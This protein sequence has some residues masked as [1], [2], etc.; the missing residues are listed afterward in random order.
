MRSVRGD[1][2]ELRS[3]LA[4]SP[5]AAR[6]SRSD[7]GEH[8]GELDRIVSRIPHLLCARSRGH[9]MTSARPL[10]RDPQATPCVEGG[11]PFGTVLFRGA[12]GGTRTHTSLRTKHFEC[13][14]STIPPRRPASLRVRL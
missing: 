8:P 2:C 4:P 5:P 12:G 7:R 3:S 11:P 9:T 13:S 6:S 14:A 1:R 10:A